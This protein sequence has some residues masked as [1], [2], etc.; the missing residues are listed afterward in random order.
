[1]KVNGEHVPNPGSDE[2]VE[3]GC[4]CARMDNNRGRWAPW[5]PDNWWVNGDC[6][7]HAS[8]EAEED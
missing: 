6:P 3:M 5:P 1:M 2:A 8:A 7:V 4:R